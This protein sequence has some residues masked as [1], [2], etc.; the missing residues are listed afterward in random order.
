MKKSVGILF[1]LLLSSLCLLAA[2]RAWSGQVV[3]DAVRGGR[4]YDNWILA[5][6]R[7]AP[8]ESHPLWD[9]QTTN[10]NAGAV[11]WLCTECH[12]WDYKGVDGAYGQFSSHYTGFKGVI[13]VVGASQAEVLIWFNGTG[14]VAHDF[15][16]YF[17]SDDVVDLVAFLRTRQADTDLMIDSFSGRSLGNAELGR[18]LYVSSCESCHG[19]AGTLI[20]FGTQAQPLYLA[21]MAVADPWRAVHKI[22]FGTPLDLR[23]PASEE[24]G[25][26]LS[27]VADVLAYVQTLE[28]GNPSLR[29]FN[30]VSSGGTTVVESQGRIEPLVWATSI[31]FVII[32]AGVAYDYYQTR[33]H[34]KGRKR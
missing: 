16:A 4:I 32:A 22:R 17:D 9:E 10:R 8:T 20:N 13:G 28:R 31:L 33:A 19:N 23:M 12:G 27:R 7:T 24:L 2:G 1:A 34:D 15:T 25:W 21:D 26:S 14:N 11:T 6:D 18:G 5:L 30:P 29:P 3:G